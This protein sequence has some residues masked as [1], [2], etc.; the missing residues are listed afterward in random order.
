[1]AMAQLLA[2]PGVRDALARSGS[3][4]LLISVV[5]ETEDAAAV[6]REVQALLGSGAL[7]RRTVDARWALALGAAYLGAEALVDD[8][9]DDLAGE[10]PPERI[11]FLRATS[12]QRAGRGVD[13]RTLLEPVLAR[14][15][16]LFSAR[17][18]LHR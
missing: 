5:G 17:R 16:L 1:P 3:P 12:L 6:V 11:A 9:V 8:Q 13:A 18:R 15:N 2:R 7:A 14:P 4:S 10:V